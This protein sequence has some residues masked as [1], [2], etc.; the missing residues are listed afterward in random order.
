MLTHP[1]HSLVEDRCK[2]A[3][4]RDREDRVE[5]LALSAVLFSL[6]RQEPRTEQQSEIA[7]PGIISQTGW[8]HKSGLARAYLE[9]AVSLGKCS[10]S[11]IRI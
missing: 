8:Q 10:A 9:G 1:V 5:H 2:V 11:L 3:H 6:S 7:R 4:V